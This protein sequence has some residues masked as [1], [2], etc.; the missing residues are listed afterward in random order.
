MAS[1][2]TRTSTSVK[3]GRTASVQGPVCVRESRNQLVFY[4]PCISPETCDSKWWNPY[5]PAQGNQKMGCIVSLLRT[6][7]QKTQTTAGSRTSKS[8]LPEF[9]SAPL[10]SM[11]NFFSG[12]KTI[13]RSKCPSTQSQA[14]G[15]AH[16]NHHFKKW[17]TGEYFRKCVPVLLLGTRQDSSST[18]LWNKRL[19]QDWQ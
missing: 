14:H 18:A 13:Q 3:I 6:Q 17:G 7:R 4:H 10:S 8:I 12:R 16:P 5:K 15:S 2:S 11:L 1:L 19:P 9:I